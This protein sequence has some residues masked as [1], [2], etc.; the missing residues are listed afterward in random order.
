MQA[1]R[2]MQRG[3]TAVRVAT[4]LVLASKEDGKPTGRSSELLPSPCPLS[5]TIDLAYKRCLKRTPVSSSLN[6]FDT[7]STR[8]FSHGGSLRH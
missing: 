8:A 3:D 2:P 7:L 1:C 5:K 4:T 6:T